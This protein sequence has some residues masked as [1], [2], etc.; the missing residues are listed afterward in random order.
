MMR[1]TTLDKARLAAFAD[2]EL[3]PEEA[4]AVVMHL[5]DHPEDQAF[6]D[7]L[8]AANAALIRAFDAPM[9]APVPPAILAVIDGQQ[10]RAKVV[11]F[12]G[13]RAFALA[14]VAL[15]ASVALA[16][17]LVPGPRPSG[18]TVGPVAQGQVLH[19]LLQSLPSGQTVPLTAAQ[20]L[21][22]LAT[23]PTT[24]G[25]CRE[26]EVIDR[27]AGRLD[28]AL[29]CTADAG[30]RVDVV[31]SEPLPD[32]PPDQAYVPAGGIE[33]EALTLWLDRLGAGMALDAATEA[34]M[35]ARGWVR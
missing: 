1:E 13:R 26:V 12:P 16:V 6:V 5:A 4:A 20:D 3:S 32:T 25:H 11:S 31:L 8:M 14:G 2:G 28:M 27:A 9:T 19:D 15:A 35:I 21:T 18:L 23:L 30:W 29:A 17:V 34:G 22:I 24:A 33:T 7:D 10:A